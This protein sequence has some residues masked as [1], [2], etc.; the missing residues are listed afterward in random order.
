M[1]S[2]KFTVNSLLIVIIII[3]A[4]GFFVTV[5]MTRMADR[6]AINEIV[7]IEG[8]DLS[9][10]YSSLEKNGIYRGDEN[11][12]SLMLE[13]DFG[14]GWALERQNGRI[15]TNEYSSSSLGLM[16]SDLVM[17]DEETFDKKVV[18]KNAV[19]IGKCKSGELVCLTDCM[20]ESNHPKTNSLCTLYCMSIA[21]TNPKSDSASIVFIDPKTEKEVYSV[22]D[23]NA[24]KSFEDK[25]LHRTLA[26]VKG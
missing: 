19:M 10:R 9:V 11:T 14:S 20:I 4:I 26:E 22:K 21:G 5:T 6:T 3:S 23:E 15:F 25:Y 17:I 16:F 12:G 7:E 8:T 2:S 1:K 18:L 13:G 24:L